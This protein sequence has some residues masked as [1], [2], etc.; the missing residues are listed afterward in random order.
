MATKVLAVVILFSSLAIGQT[1]FVPVEPTGLP[2][3]IVIT[4]III[5]NNIIPAGTE[6]AVFDDTLCVGA[7]TYN[8]TFNLNL[9]AWQGDPSMDL[10]GFS[11]GNQILFKA[12]LP[13]QNG[14]ISL[15][16][17]FTQGNG[18]FSNGAFSVVK[19]NA[20]TTDV[21]LLKD[22]K[23]ERTLRTFPNPFN[24][25]CNIIIPN[26]SGSGYDL[27]I[28]SLE[29]QLVENIRVDEGTV[30]KWDTKLR[31]GGDLNSGIYVVV[32]RN[33]LNVYSNKII[34]VK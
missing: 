21:E 9:T 18:H 19:L 22:T 4:E 24:S 15:N 8:G 28:Y 23:K 27:S 34:M 32:L 33:K 10:P 12:Y 3:N 6:I 7:V 5:K 26:D 31:N 25:Q 11:P 16:S 30:I 1:Y 13:L 17:N 20:V 29:G 14:V 2:Y